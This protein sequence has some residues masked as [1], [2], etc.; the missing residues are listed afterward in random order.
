[1]RHGGDLVPQGVDSGGALGRGAPRGAAVDVDGHGTP[2]D[3]TEEALPQVMPQRAN[4]AYSLS[5]VEPTDRKISGQYVG[6]K[7]V[8][9][10]HSCHED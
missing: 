3:V 2:G 8:N 5:D 7:G 10:L 1:M 4:L 6:A 9:L